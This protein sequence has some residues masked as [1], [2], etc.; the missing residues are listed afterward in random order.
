MDQKDLNKVNINPKKMKA[1]T[2]QVRKDRKNDLYGIF[3]CDH[4]HQQI[5]INKF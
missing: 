3:Q 1:R 4:W 2:I 5:K